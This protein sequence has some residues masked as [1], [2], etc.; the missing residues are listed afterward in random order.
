MD[1]DQQSG[2]PTSFETAQDQGLPPPGPQSHKIHFNVNL[3]GAKRAG[4]EPAASSKKPRTDGTGIADS[5]D[6]GTAS[7]LVDTESLKRQLVPQ[8]AEIIIPSYSAWFHMDRVNEVE[9][10]ALPEF[11]NSRNRS[12]TPTI[13]L[14]YRNFM[15]NTYRL[16]PSEYLTVTACR[17]NLAGDV[18][19]II[20]VH[21][22]L[23]QWGLIN[24]QADPESRPSAYGPAFTGHFRIT[25]ETPRGLQPLFPAMSLPSKKPSTKSSSTSQSLTS[26]TAGGDKS[27]TLGLAVRKDLFASE[28]GVEA[29]EEPTDVTPPKR[30]KIS[31][32]TCTVDCTAQR[33]H[34]AK[35]PNMDV[36]PNCFFEG[37]F[38]ST[39]FSGDFIRLEE[40]SSTDSDAWTDQETLL[41]L[42]GLEMYEDNWDA[43]AEHVGTRTRE[44]C[45]LKFV[46]MPIEDPFVGSRQ[47][48]LGPLQ[49]A[50]NAP[51][52]AAE[53][54]VLTLVAYL[55][56]VVDPRAAKAAAR[57][58][59]EAV[60]K[61]EGGGDGE[62][63]GGASGKGPDAMDTS[64]DNAGGTSTTTGPTA[65]ARAAVTAFGSAAA[66]AHALANNEERET[67]RLLNELMEVQLK[68]VQVKMQ[69]V[70]ELER[71]LEQERKE[72]ER[73][74][75]QLFLERLHLRKQLVQGPT[76]ATGS[77]HPQYR[78]VVNGDGTA[79]KPAT[80]PGNGNQVI[81]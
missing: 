9:K 13:Y 29:K 44:E 51:F 1:L 28:G 77:A 65:I 68:K 60:P 64:D 66:K 34:C 54:P 75:Q 59:I 22:F 40:R 80:V 25:A 48:E 5:A 33:Y 21:A 20:R 63:E 17:R 16:N 38:P 61:D 23:E 19:A 12:K 70:A 79:Q 14:D 81:V 73:Q 2:L 57:A 18:C 26:G 55:A 35:Q 42:E 71:L 72:I 6:V 7:Q 74:R 30:P 10:R 62:G 27:S 24:Y 47:S 50:A 31:C 56:S 78:V 58:A 52:S 37:R 41:L 36:C 53:N 45:V 3:A 43:I 49:F 46:D 4:E 67:Q 32:S 69:H 15:V 76:D 8:T 11:F 39:L